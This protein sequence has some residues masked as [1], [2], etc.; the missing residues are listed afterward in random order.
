MTKIE[1]MTRTG[2]HTEEAKQELHRRQLGA[3][4][5]DEGSYERTKEL[6][7]TSIGIGRKRRKAVIWMNLQRE[8]MAGH[9]PV[10]EAVTNT[11]G[12]DEKPTTT[13]LTTKK[14]VPTRVPARKM[15][16]ERK[17]GTKKEQTQTT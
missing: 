1:R 17:T 2:E 6:Q 7:A 3:M 10:T 16:Q 14:K 9:A 15:A 5:T 4:R 13:R 12:E 11:K 8:K